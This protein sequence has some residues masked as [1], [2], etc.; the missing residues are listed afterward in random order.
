MGAAAWILVLVLGVWLHPF[1]GAAGTT[2]AQI[3]LATSTI[4]VSTSRVATTT[5]AVAI[6]VSTTTAAAGTTTTN[7][8]TTA[9]TTAVPTS[10]VP[11]SATSPAST[12]M[13]PTPASGSEPSA[14]STTANQ[15]TVNG[16]GEAGATVDDRGGSF[17]PVATALIVL[18]SLA[19][20]AALGFIAY[21]HLGPQK[22]PEFERLTD[23]PMNTLK[24]ESPFA[25]YGK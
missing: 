2:S 7:A 9:T 23:L 6:P 12:S 16:T 11:T 21:R 25:R 13:A 19:V 8:T 1:A 15:T 18:L 3:P 22:G 24:E 20:I 10:A 4:A 5:P 14:T 17:P